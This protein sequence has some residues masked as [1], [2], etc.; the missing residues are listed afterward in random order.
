MLI[1]M[2]LFCLGFEIYTGIKVAKKKLFMLHSKLSMGELCKK[3]LR[4]R[5]REK[6]I[7]KVEKVHRHA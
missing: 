7:N 4:E 5:K 6:H 2:I 3:I 1:N